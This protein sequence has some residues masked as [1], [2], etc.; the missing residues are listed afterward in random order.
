VLT[1][2]LRQ[3]A[4]PEDVVVCF[5]SD[6]AATASGSAATESATTALGRLHSNRHR[7]AQA[8]SRPTL[9]S[10][11]RAAEEVPRASDPAS[12]SKR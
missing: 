5:F 12:C 11:L 4:P 9:S 6:S 2:T 7:H 1:L 8:S 3:E 10:F